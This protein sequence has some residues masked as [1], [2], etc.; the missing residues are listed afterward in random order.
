MQ[1]LWML[2]PPPPINLHRDL[3]LVHRK[4]GR[5]IRKLEAILEAGEAP[6]SLHTL[7]RGL[8][9]DHEAF[10]YK[11]MAI[12]RQDEQDRQRQE[13]EKQKNTL[14]EAR[15]YEQILR[16]SLKKRR[17]ESEDEEEEYP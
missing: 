10:C 16:K 6:V 7:Y 2:E 3:Y 4:R 17:D 13:K 12:R 14:A 15:K 1:R 11:M 9:R 5:R 8:L